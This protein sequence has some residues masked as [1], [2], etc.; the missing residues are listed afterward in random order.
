MAHPDITHILAADFEPDVLQQSA[1]GPVLV[2]FWAEWCGPC[3]SLAPLLE[4]LVD[5]LAG[6]LKI[7]KV[8]TDVE[9]EL[10]AQ[11]GIRSLPTL[12]LF[13]DGKSVG[14][15]VGAQPLSALEEFVQ[16]WLPRPNDALIEQATAAAETGDIAAAIA[17][18]EQALSADPADYR[19]HP[20]LGGLYMDD[21]RQQQAQ[22][23]LSELPANIAV[24]TSFDGLKARLNMADAG[25]EDDG[26]DPIAQVFNA[27]IN[28]AN[29]GNHDSAVSA[30]I[31]LLPTEKAWRDGAIGKALVD[32]FKVLEGDPRLREW[33]RQMARV[34]N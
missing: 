22:T 4:Q 27:A 2:D 6:Q 18:L 21:G 30:W 16:P 23:L 12:M 26:D 20:I 29:A 25:A 17:V 5:G 1:S 34:L 32:I 33:R 15:L 28:N 14:Q 9:P 31:G 13:R 19:I 11:H 10:A 7:V 3:K 8:D 24:D